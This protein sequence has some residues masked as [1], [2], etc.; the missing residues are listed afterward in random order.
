MQGNHFD[1]GNPGQ[2]EVMSQEPKR[3]SQILS[4]WMAIGISVGV[5]LGAV[6]DNVGLGIALGV[7]I[8]AGW[9]QPIAR[10]RKASQL[11]LPAF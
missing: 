4:V 6:L 11:N 9:V 1:L 8:G 2:G 10:E 7:A 3:T 5:A